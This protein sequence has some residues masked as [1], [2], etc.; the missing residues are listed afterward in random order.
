MFKR[1]IGAFILTFGLTLGTLGMAHANG[2]RGND[3]SAPELDPSILGSGAAILAGGVILLNE[4]RRN[5]K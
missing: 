2:W 1:I 3:P 4:R 5:R